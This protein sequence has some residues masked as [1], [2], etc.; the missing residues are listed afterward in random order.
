MLAT[1]AA[2]AADATVIPYRRILIVDDEDAIL[3]SMKEY[4]S[5]QGFAVDCAQEMEEAEA[6]LANIQYAAVIV[7]LRLTGTNGTEGLEIVRYIKER[8]PWTR[9]VLLTAYGSPEVELEARRRGIDAFLQKPMSLSKVERI[10][11][12]VI[13]SQA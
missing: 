13:G 2:D 6:L 1:D 12:E 9:I 8:C 4:L 3:F 10:V 5:G 7:D 11:C